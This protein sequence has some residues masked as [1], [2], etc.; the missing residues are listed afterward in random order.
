MDPDLKNGGRVIFNYE[1]T[2]ISQAAAT[3][4]AP[5]LESRS[6]NPMADELR[7]SHGKE[8]GND[9][10]HSD[11]AGGDTTGKEYP[12]K[13]ISTVRQLQTPEAM[14]EPAPWLDL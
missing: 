6:A 7:E 9:A 10:A 8:A 13:D 11:E 1:P 5:Q 4:P 12:E 3:E 2:R 14:P